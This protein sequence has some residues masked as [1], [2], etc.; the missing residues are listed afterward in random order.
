MN[1]ETDDNS[2]MDSVTAASNDNNNKEDGSFTVENSVSESSSTTLSKKE[3]WD[4]TFLVLAFSCVVATLT[5]VVGTGAVVILSVGGSPSL[6]PFA[7]A[8]VFMGMSFVSLTATHWIFI[9]WGRKIG[10]WVGCATGIV[11]VLLGCLGLVQSSPAIVLVAQ[12]FM[13]GGLGMGMYLRYSAVEVVP[14]DF[15]SRAVTWVLAGGCLAAFI[16]PETAQA[17]KGVFGDDN[18]TYIGTFLV[19]GCFFILQAICVALVGFPLPQRPAIK[20][21]TRSDDDDGK[22]DLDEEA[23]NTDK[24][25]T[26]S[27]TISSNE[28]A[29]NEVSLWSIVHESS[30]LLPVGVAILSW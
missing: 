17:T 6:A 9:L 11:G 1:T 25:L 10:F 2:K 12:T 7:L 26:T 23:Q 27:E 22:T 3:L 16:G 14:P 29:S 5:L 20:P 21:P 8:V 19:A 15:S 13:G 24:N 28:S 30:F 18:L 4:I